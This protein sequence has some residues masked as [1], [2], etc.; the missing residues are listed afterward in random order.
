MKYGKVFSHE[1]E[2]LDLSLP[3]DHSDTIKAFKSKKNNPV[4]VHVG[5]AKWGIKEWV[6]LIY[7]RN[8]KDKF[9]LDQYVKNFNG[10]EMNTTF[11]SIKKENVENWA[12]RAPDGFRF[13]PKFLRSISHLKR[14]NDAGYFT[15]QFLDAA[16]AFGEK[17]GPS[18][19]QLPDNFAGRQLESLRKYVQD[20]PDDFPMFV[21]LRHTDWFTD[22]A[23]FDETFTMMAEQKRGVVLTDVGGRRDVLHMRLTVPK[24]FIRFNGYNLHPSDY[25]R[26]DEWVQRIK[27]WI[28]NGL[29]EL[30]FYA[31][32]EDETHTPVTCDY[33]IKKINEA[34]NLNIARP[35]FVTDNAG[36]PGTLFP[37]I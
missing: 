18:F 28:Q 5:C 13:S 10:I 8:T 31:H 36:M 32:Q 24:V 7:P 1:L 9:F 30:Y 22:P 26:L 37:D 33:F 16:E 21:E 14:L 27:Y 19:L 34:C 23:I 2:H 20:I 12:S 35:D 4:K 15:D 3:P 6:G 25:Q 17:L 11:Y 29:E